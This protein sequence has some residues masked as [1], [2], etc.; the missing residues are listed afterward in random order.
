MERI[1]CPQILNWPSSS[2]CCNLNFFLHCRP[3]RTF[4]AKTHLYIT[5]FANAGF[6]P[7][8]APLHITLVF[9][10]P[11]GVD[12][13]SQWYHLKRV[14]V[15]CLVQSNCLYPRYIRNPFLEQILHYNNDFEIHK[16]CLRNWCTLGKQLNLLH[17]FRK[18]NLEIETHTQTLF[19]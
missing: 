8:S 5:H 10:A 14:S 2:F 16:M 15:P 6:F 12:I 7:G 4:L 17:S 18:S 3:V 13:R 1:C 19:P 11:R 9:S